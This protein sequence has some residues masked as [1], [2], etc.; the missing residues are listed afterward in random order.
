VTPVAFQAEAAAAAASVELYKE[1][2]TM[3]VFHE[4]KLKAIVSTVSAPVIPDYAA[5]R[6]AIPAYLE[7]PPV[8]A[9]PYVPT[10]LHARA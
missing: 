4:K 2:T 7:P 9:A 10:P 5:M 8:I 3:S 1:A 6:S